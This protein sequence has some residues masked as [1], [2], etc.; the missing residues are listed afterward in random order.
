MEDKHR[1]LGCP[2]DRNVPHC[3][4]YLEHNTWQNTLAKLGEFTFETQ[5][6]H[7]LLIFTKTTYVFCIYAHKKIFFAKYFSYDGSMAYF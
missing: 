5:N 6:Q 7:K 2:E 1:L 4:L 3:E